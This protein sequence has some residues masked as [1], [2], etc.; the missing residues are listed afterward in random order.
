M[1]I[2]IG[3]FCLRQESALSKTATRDVC[4]QAPARFASMAAIGA[5][6]PLNLRRTQ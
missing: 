4:F 6:L 3:G 5:K 2:E 1:A